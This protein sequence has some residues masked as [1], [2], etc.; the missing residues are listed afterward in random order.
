MAKNRSTLP[1]VSRT[2]VN[3]ISREPLTARLA[4]SMSCCRIALFSA[5]QRFSAENGSPEV[6]NQQVTSSS[7][8]AGSKIYRRGPLHPAWRAPLAFAPFRARLLLLFIR[9][10]RPR[11]PYTACRAVAHVSERRRA[12]S[13]D[14]SAERRRTSRA[15]FA[16]ARRFARAFRYPGTFVPGLSAEAANRIRSVGGTPYT[17]CRAEAHISERRRALSHDSSRRSSQ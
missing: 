12:L 3:T 16:W 5:M 13:H 14:S 11:T 1:D 4:S 10:L 2:R 8:V 17:A 15:P 9:G 7:L 6:R